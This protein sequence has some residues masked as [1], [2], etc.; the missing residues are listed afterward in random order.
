MAAKKKRRR[1]KRST[2]K[3]KPAKKAKKR[4]SKAKGHIP[5]RVLE[6]RLHRLSALVARR[7][8]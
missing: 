6:K 5:L 4:K 2:A 1:A 3:R 7:R 8:K